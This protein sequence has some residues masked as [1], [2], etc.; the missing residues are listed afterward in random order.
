MNK[1]VFCIQNELAEKGD[2]VLR[3]LPLVH[4]VHLQVC[5]ESSWD[6]QTCWKPEYL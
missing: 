2:F 6:G 4:S 5:F 3:V 1:I